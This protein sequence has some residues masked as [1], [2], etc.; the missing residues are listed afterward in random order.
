[1]DDVREVMKCFGELCDAYL[2]KPIDLNQLLKLMT[3]Y[4]LIDPPGS[5]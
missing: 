5:I 1:V 3:T 4:K 2:T